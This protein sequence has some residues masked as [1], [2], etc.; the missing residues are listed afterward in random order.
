M[1]S[2][3]DRSYYI[4]AS[5]TSF[6]VGNWETKTFARWY[7]VKQGIYEMDYTNVSM[8]A[9]TYYEHRILDSLGLPGLTKDR[10]IIHGRLRINLDGN[11]LDKIY[12]VKTYR[13]EKGFHV[14]KK[15]RDQVQVQMYGSRIYKACI[16]AYGLQEGDY[17]N[18][19]H[20]IDPERRSIHEIEYDSEF[21][22]KI[23]LP[24]YWHLC[25]CLDQGRFPKVS[26]IHE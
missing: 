5:D 25:R 20:D 7:G 9:G 10:Q 26:D 17:R 2:S 13:Y 6:V 3:K 12:E 22:E 8:M 19:Y 14:P 24:R 11:T 15:Y 16:V 23:Y 21:I 18:F 4:G 1:I